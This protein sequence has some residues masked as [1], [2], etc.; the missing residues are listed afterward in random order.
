LRA[1]ICDF[2]GVIADDETPHFVTYQQALKEF[3]IELSREDYYGIY[4]GMDE[5]NCTIALMEKNHGRV[6]L[7]R[8]R[9]I[10]E[11]KADLFHAYATAH[12]P[13]LLP[14]VVAFVNTARQYYRLALA[15]GG[16]R[17]QIEDALRERPIE[18][19]FPVIVSAEDTTLGKPDPAI[20]RVA[21][22]Q[23]NETDPRP[24]PRSARARRWSSK[25]RRRESCQHAQPA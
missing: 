7:P 24:E 23:L 22:Q 1:I 19:D 3:G 8:L 12:K 5:R 4:Q 2:N 13:R 16:R 25:T 9:A 14:G 11:R 10:L 6:D 15:S 17:E 21:L 18:K 20:Y